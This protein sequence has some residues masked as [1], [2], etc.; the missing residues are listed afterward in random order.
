MRKMRSEYLC[1]GN[2]DSHSEAEIRYDVFL[3]GWDA[4]DIWGPAGV[5]SAMTTLC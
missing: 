2:G 5:I 3:A 1:H 4:A